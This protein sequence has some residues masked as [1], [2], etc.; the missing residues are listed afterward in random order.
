M[1]RFL[2]SVFIKSPKGMTLGAAYLSIQPLPPKSKPK[3]R[4]FLPKYER[5]VSVIL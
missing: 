1:L 4:G 2:P 3:C 5:S